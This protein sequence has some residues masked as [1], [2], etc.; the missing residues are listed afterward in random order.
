MSYGPGFCSVGRDACRECEPAE[1]GTLDGIIVGGQLSP[2]QSRAVNHSLPATAV[3]ACPLQDQDCPG[4]CF[5][6]SNSYDGDLAVL[7]IWDR[8]LSADDIKRNMMRER[9]DSESGLAA[10]YLF[11]SDSQTSASGEEVAI[12]HSG[13][14]LH[15]A[16]SLQAVLGVLVH[17]AALP[18]SAYCVACSTNPGWQE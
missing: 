6:P 3:L 15:T 17:R 4:G 14:G 16:A 10:L 18:C 2:A 12:D 11:G 5:S 1:I 9:P 13:E 7:R 8:V